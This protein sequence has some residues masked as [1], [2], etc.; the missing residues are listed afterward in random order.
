MQVHPTYH[1]IRT[2]IEIS[3]M[4]YQDWDVLVFPDVCKIPLQEFKTSCHVVPDPGKCHIC[5]SSVDVTAQLTGSAESHGSLNNPFLL[6]T[7]TSFIPSLSAGDA[8]RISIHCWQNPEISRY[9]RLL[10]KPSDDIVFEA[11]LFVDG[12]IVG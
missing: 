4:R 9:V 6:P 1:S 2:S 11:R 3:K 8:F 7:V 5:L 10:S 12:R